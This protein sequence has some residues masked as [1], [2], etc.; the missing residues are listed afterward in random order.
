MDKQRKR[1][2]WIRLQL[3]IRRVTDWLPATRGQVRAVQ[4]DL[5]EVRDDAHDARVYL[6]LPT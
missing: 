4:G 5:N 6:G 2:R 3:R 1:Q